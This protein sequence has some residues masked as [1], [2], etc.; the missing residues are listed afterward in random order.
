MVEPVNAL[1]PSR[2][3]NLDLSA[4]GYQ[5]LFRTDETNR[6][7]GCGHSQWLVGRITAECCLC[8]TAISLAEAELSGV[9][10]HKAVALHLVEPTSESGG[11]E[12]R[13]E[14]RTPVNDRVLGL[15]VDGAP[16]P[17]AIHNISQ[18]GLMGDALPG[19]SEARLLQIELEDGTLLPAMLKW[20]D[21]SV[22][23]FA[24]L[25]PAKAVPDQD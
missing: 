16:H 9:N 18:G 6:C 7:P 22:A 21:G 19:I 25:S 13:R 10:S 17:F 11:R 24:F 4:R 20:T 12:L 15:Y 1:S 3:F 5:V 2:R 23:G 8:G 14:P